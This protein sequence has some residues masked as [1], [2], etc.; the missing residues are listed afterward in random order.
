MENFHNDIWSSYYYRKALNDSP[1]IIP[2]QLVIGGENGQITISDPGFRDT[3][4]TFKSRKIAK[5]VVIS[6]A[7]TVYNWN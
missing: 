1:V 3:N 7:C 2:E 5:N 4:V 6:G